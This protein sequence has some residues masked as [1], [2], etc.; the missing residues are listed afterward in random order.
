M[1]NKQNPQYPILV[2]DDNEVNLRI[3]D[4]HLRKAGIDNIITCDDSRQAMDMFAGYPIEIALIDLDMPHVSGHELL[5][6]I[7]KQFPDIPVIIVTGSVEIETVVQCVRSGAHDYVIKPV[8]PHLLITSVNRALDLRKLKRENDMLRQH[9]MS[10]PLEHPEVFSTILTQN[11]KM[12]NI[13]K[14]IESV[15][16]TSHPVL[17]TGETG[18]GKEKIAHTI[19]ELSDRRGSLVTVNIAGLDD[20]MFSDTL[21]G[22]VKGAFT[23]ADRTRLGMIERA[24]RGTIFLDEIGDLHMTSQVKLLRLLQEGEYLP[25]GQD[26]PHK[27]DARIIAATNK[28]LWKLQE[29]G[30]FREDLNYRLRFHHI[31][32]PPLRQRME[33]L[34]LLVD[35][36]LG[37]VAQEQKKKKPTPPK[38]LFTLLETYTFPG[39]I[40]E[41][42]TM[43]VDAVSRH[44]SKMLSLDAFK[45][46]IL[47]K[48]GNNTFMAKFDIKNSDV[49]T[50]HETLPSI[51]HATQLLVAEAMKRAGNNQSIAARMI[52]ISQP[53]LNKRLKSN[54]LQNK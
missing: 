4:L 34:P 27:T 17:I 1:E 14:Y 28:D 52:G 33:D 53:A 10:D 26:E 12:L 29:D 30:T 41:L 18:V 47:P 49:L 11:K 24:S 37:Q 9:I 36:F 5:G 48:S 31:H 46:Y 45:S 19:H 22:H 32:I 20:N 6:M 43:I 21:F 25:L 7:N 16:P 54:T 23:G 39:N 15:S 42:Q 8:D 44:K 2:V 35:Y 40:R 50:F 13:F 51:K 3:V 38:E